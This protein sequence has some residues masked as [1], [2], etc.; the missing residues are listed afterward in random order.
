[1]QEGLNYWNYCLASVEWSTLQHSDAEK[2]FGKIKIILLSWNEIVPQGIKLALCQH[3]LLKQEKDK[4]VLS[5]MN[6]AQQTGRGRGGK[7]P[8]QLPY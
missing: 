2:D 3:D 6:L 1:M 4:C 7:K 5:Q 8:H